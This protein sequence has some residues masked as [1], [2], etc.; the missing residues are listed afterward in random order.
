MRTF[1]NYGGIDSGNTGQAAIGVRPVQ[2]FSLRRRCAIAITNMGTVDVFL[3]FNS[4][5]TINEGQLLVGIK[6]ASIVLEAAT[7]IWAV[8]ASAAQISWMELDL[9]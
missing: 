9:A 6:G 3:G 2:L 8:C 5:V 4:N 7:S 1:Q